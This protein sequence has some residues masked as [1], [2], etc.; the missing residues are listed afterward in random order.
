LQ[1]NSWNSLRSTLAAMAPAVLLRAL[2]WLWGMLENSSATLADALHVALVEPGLGL[3]VL[4]YIL[5]IDP[6][7]LDRTC[8]L[9]PHVDDAAFG[10]SPPAFMCEAIE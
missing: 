8:W 3:T 9:A 5:C 4:L 10:D 7:A 6:C 1:F 2:R